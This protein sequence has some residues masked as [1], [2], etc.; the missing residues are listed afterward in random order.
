LTILDVSPAVA[1]KFGELRASLLDAGLPL[2]EMDLFIAS[3]AIV[4]NL[5]LVTHNTRDYATVP[6]LRLLDWLNP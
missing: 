1:P 5:T 6:G 3:T 2:P 4:H